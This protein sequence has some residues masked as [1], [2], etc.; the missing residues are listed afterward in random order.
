MCFQTVEIFG[1]VGSTVDAFVATAVVGI[2]QLVATSGKQ[3]VA[4]LFEYWQLQSILL[5][6][7]FMVNCYLWLAVAVFESEDFSI[8]LYFSF[9]VGLIYIL[10]LNLCLVSIPLVDMAGRKLLLMISRYL[11]INFFLKSRPLSIYL[12]IVPGI[13]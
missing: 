6:L 4:K 12:Y 11:S 9:L 8:D 13:K 1:A 2:V 5:P 7:Y 3:L 10:N